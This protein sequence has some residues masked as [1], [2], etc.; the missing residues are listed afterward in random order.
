MNKRIRSALWVTA[1]A[2]AFPGSRGAADPPAPASAAD[3]AS[4]IQQLKAGAAMNW[5]KIPWVPSLLEARRAS[6]EEKS[7]LFLFTHDG[8]LATGRC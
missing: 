5:T 7:P 2:L 8:N 6:Q 1:V 4:R 3:V